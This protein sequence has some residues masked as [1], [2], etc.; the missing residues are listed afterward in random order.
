MTAG[1]HPSTRYIIANA[2]T[3][4]ASQRL[5]GMILGIASGGVMS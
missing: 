2:A 4:P 1:G 5:P 3:V